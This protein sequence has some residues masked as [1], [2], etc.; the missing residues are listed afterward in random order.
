M[1][2]LFSRRDALLVT[3]AAITAPAVL[4]AQ[5]DPARP[6][7]PVPEL[8]QGE[9]R[10]GIRHHRMAIRR[11]RHA[12][13]QGIASDTIGIDAE[14]LGRTITMR[15]GER[16]RLDV[17]N[18]LDEEATLHWHG[19]ELPAVADGGPH[20]PMAPGATWTAEFEVR[21]R[22]GTYWYHGHRMGA[23]GRHV[24]FG[25][26]G[27]IRL[28]GDDE[29]AVGLPATYG[30]DD[31]PLVLQDRWFARDGSLH[32]RPNGH[33]VMMGMSGDI[34]ITNGVVDP[35]AEVPA[36]LVRLR[37]LNGSNASI[38][39]VRFAD[40][41]PFQHIATDGGL[42]GE[43]VTVRHLLLAP[44]E[45]AEIL[46]DLADGQ[47]RDLVGD[48]A[49]MGMMGGMMRGAGAGSVTGLTFRF[50]TLQPSGKA[51]KTAILARL[52]PLEP[53][54]I[55]DGVITRR[56]NLDMGG[57]GPL[58]MLTGAA[59]FTINGRTMKASRIDFSVQA[60]ATEIWE[61]VN[62]TGM[63]HP[64]HVHNTQFRILDRNGRP[65]GPSETGFKDT[66][67][68]PGGSTVRVLAR[69]PE[70]ADERN[71]YMYHC[72]ILEHEDAG[73]M[74]QFTVV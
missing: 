19:M 63:A 43:P 68:V 23:T 62:R 67:L 57:M 31:I 10:S 52:S 15:G 65:P 11:G 5:I 69:F 33:D 64:M 37:L 20:Q 1:S 12:F 61:F 72:H 50:A 9:V 51:R 4:R 8:V 13:A 44:G 46:V 39:S 38:Y 40:G 28:E 27:L 74:G 34:G 45:R 22:P 24:W 71:P 14:F 17:T 60:G 59:P 3:A 36:G 42:L 6:A 41:T 26:A 2:M 35:V 18:H 25:M 73:M 56:F 47:A 30:I 32:Y 48:V 66:V 21:Q 16:V 55:P 58:R 70:Y 54:R 49:A 29:E 7:L 53:V